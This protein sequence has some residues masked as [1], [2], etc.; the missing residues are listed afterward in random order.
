M[1]ESHFNAWKYQHPGA[2]YR[3]RRQLIWATLLFIGSL[4][5]I[6]LWPLALALFAASLVCLLISSK[7]I[8][9]G[10]RY[11]ICGSEIVYFANLARLDRYD[12]LGTLRLT[13]HDQACFVL[14][15]EKFP[16]NARKADKISRNKAAK[17]AKVAD[18]IVAQVRAANPAAMIEYHC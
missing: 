8:L 5:A 2:G 15:R 1:D 16:T 3:S 11:L 6:K 7:K 12:T 9:V 18:R 14:E 17:F 10:S 4:L 13:S